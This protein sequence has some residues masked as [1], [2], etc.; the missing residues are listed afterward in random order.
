MSF[1]QSQS[2]ENAMGVWSG[3]DATVIGE[4]REWLHCPAPLF[5]T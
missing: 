5:F 4:Y 1:F 2:S 3:H